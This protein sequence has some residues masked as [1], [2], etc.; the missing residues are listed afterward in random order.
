MFTPL[1]TFTKSAVLM[2]IYLLFIADI[3]SVQIEP[4]NE[5]FSEASNVEVC[6]LLDFYYDICSDNTNFTVD[7]LVLQSPGF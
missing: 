3:R 4:K 7:L 6:A 1:L 2:V 5:E